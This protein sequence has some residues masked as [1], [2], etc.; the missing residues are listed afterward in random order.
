MMEIRVSGDDIN[1][2]NGLRLGCTM[3]PIL[4]NLYSAATVT[5]WNGCCPKAEVVSRYKIGRK[6][7]GDTTAKAR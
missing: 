5:C 2:R 4:F 6:L 3:A 1:I 7:V